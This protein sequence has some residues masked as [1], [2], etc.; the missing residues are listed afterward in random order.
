MNQQHFDVI[1][2]GGGLAGLTTA[3]YL[4]RAGINVTVVEKSR[5][6]GGRATTQEK[7]GFLFNQGPHALYIEGE[8][9][10]VLTELG[11]PFRGKKPLR[12]GTSFGVLNGRLH[13]LPSDP[14][15]TLQTDLLTGRDKLALAVFYVKLMG[16]QPEDVVDQSARAWLNDAVAQPDLLRLLTMLGRVATYTHALDQLSAQVLVQQMRYALGKNVLYLDGGWQSLVDGLRNRA[17][18]YGVALRTGHSAAA[19]SEEDNG[20]VVTLANKERLTAR[21][22]VLTGSPSSIANLLPLHP[23]VQ[24]WRETAVPVRVALLDVALSQLPEPN[25]LLAFGLEQPTYLAVHS[26]FARLAPQDGALLHVAKYLNPGETG[27]EARNELEAHLSL[28]QP[29]WRDVLVHARFLPEMT[30]THWLATAQHGGMNG[31]A[32]LQIP[33]QARLFLAG[34]WV[35]TKGW[36][37]DASF[38]S[39]KAIAQR[40]VN[41]LQYS[42]SSDEGSNRVPTAAN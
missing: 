9:H 21:Y 24:R 41:G 1:I 13:L 14:R 37:A 35:G 38:A 3:V 4:A 32:P 29:G 19:V 30:V 22:V 23:Q 27:A 34:D 33:G 5:S 12:A 11:V 2:V 25:R 16:T 36:L 42:L 17:V 28:V 39:A 15:A 20:V 10:A 8:G 31:R 18:Q 40:I 7:E 26:S 6:L